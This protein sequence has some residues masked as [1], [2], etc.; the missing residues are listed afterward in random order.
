MTENDFLGDRMENHTQFSFPSR[1]IKLVIWDLDETFW[2]GTLSEGGI[3]PNQEHIRWVRHLTDQG[4]INSIC[5]KN[6]HDAVEQK[7]QELGIRDLFVFLSA[8]WTPKGERIR[9][10]IS[11]MHLR[12]ENVLFLDDNSA[13]LQE[14][15]FYSPGLHIAHPSRIPELMGTPA[16][17]GKADPGHRRLEQ[18][19]LLEQKEKAAKEASSNEAFL[20]TSKI[21]VEMIEDCA[22][23][24]DRIHE[25]IHRNNQLNFTKDR[26]T[27][28]QVCR[29][30]L[31]DSIRS[32][33]VQVS[34]RFG[35]HGIVGCYAVENGRAL[36]FVFS[37]RILGMGVEQWVYSQ[38]G[39]PEL[40][41]VGEVAVRLDPE[42]TPDWINVHPSDAP[43]ETLRPAD[44]RRIIVY[45]TCPLRPTWSYL[46]QKYPHTRFTQVD[47]EPS[48]CNLAAVH[49]ETP[50]MI[51]RW[52]AG[53]TVFDANYSFYP[54]V[55]DP[56]TD[57]VLVNLGSEL[58]FCKYT[59]SVDGSYFF[60]QELTGDT[61][62]AEILR[63]YIPSPVTPEDVLREISFLCNHLPE[64]TILL[65]QTVAE[66][67]FPVKGR[68]RNY[69]D[70]IR[71]NQL[72]EELAARFQRIRLIEIR[73]LA[74]H[75]S[76]FFNPWAYH[77]NRAIGYE[78]AMRVCRCLGWKEDV[79]TAQP[80][81]AVPD[82]AISRTLL[83]DGYRFHYTLFLRNGKLHIT[84]ETDSNPISACSFRFWCGRSL[85]YASEPSAE[86]ACSLRIDVPGRWK[87][88]VEVQIGGK[89]LTFTTEEIDY[90]AYN[91]FQ[92][93]GPK[94]PD[95]HG[96]MSGLPEF[97]DRN[98]HYA[99]V[100]HTITT[101]I[102]QLAAS[103]VNPASFFL[104]RG[105]REISL[106]ADK[107]I[108]DVLVPF[109]VHS[110]LKLKKLYTT[111]PFGGVTADG[112]IHAQLFHDIHSD[113][114]L[115]KGDVLL[116]ASDGRNLDKRRSI[117]ARIGVQV[118]YLWDVLS[119]LMTETFFVRYFADR[120]IPHVLCARTANLFPYQSF[121]YHYIKAN[122]RSTFRTLSDDA[123]ALAAVK[124]GD[125]L[126]PQFA[127][128][129]K[130]EL[131][132]TLVRPIFVTDRTT[133]A[134]APLDRTGNYVNISH[135]HRCTVGQPA[136]SS[137]SIYLFG[138]AFAFGCSV[139]DQDTIASRL[140]V[141]VGEEYRVCNCANYWYESQI[142]TMLRLI[143]AMDFREDD[144]LVVLLSNWQEETVP[145]RWHWLNWDAVKEPVIRLDLF[146][147]FQKNGRSDLFLLPCAYTAE[148]NDLIAETIFREIKHRILPNRSI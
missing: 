93:A 111:D 104:E 39:F 81:D 97:S 26:I 17:S 103:G 99:A 36:Q 90:N 114:E 49:R 5:S 94:H 101:Q 37:C 129:P 141:M 98:Q 79:E 41:I 30:F 121:P 122:E 9:D 142:G 128:I 73:D 50:E 61:A 2:H 15:A 42:R 117:F 82:N 27:R 147:L 52:L 115:G 58:S 140:Q 21:R 120:N 91:Y 45:G 95:F 88:C 1:Q 125:P 89:Q 84:V 8:D 148:C 72:S 66:T 134:A 57:A 25:M 133:A 59:S 109:L 63:E 12:S 85:E 137:R 60:S 107:E 113:I 112:D 102:S 64:H 38:L 71:I 136:D 105:I 78:L 32:G 7:L 43:T 135:G 118:F 6:D 86:C 132:E 22:A 69:H 24:I 11:H 106:F 34:D 10:I 108:A 143:D 31:N 33:I 19:R 68:D 87:V 100:R 139:S 62:S 23:H 92:Y 76:D 51:G 28:D 20:R 74:K 53:I 127:G 144:I 146:P 65:I 44:D 46:Q 96:W 70:R 126:P 67:E 35:D 116:F 29:I 83:L 110:P 124:R 3:V 119:S 80:A 138:G 14:A 75:P 123:G 145:L 47:P 131:L 16:L 77:F 13:N 55:F 18:Y 56:K 4:I 130:E 54:D 40:E 48:V